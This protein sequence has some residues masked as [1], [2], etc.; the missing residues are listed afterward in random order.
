MGKLSKE[1]EEKLNKTLDEV[2]K[3]KRKERKEKKNE[4]RK[5]E[6][7]AK[8]EDKRQKASDEKERPASIHLTVEGE[9]MKKLF[10]AAGCKKDIRD[11]PAI[12]IVIS[13]N[14]KK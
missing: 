14:M 6:K 1:T 9:T 8:K 11:Y 7:P 2:T 5:N 3:D 13:K 12:N 4:S 10:I